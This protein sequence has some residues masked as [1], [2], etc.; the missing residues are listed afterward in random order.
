MDQDEDEG[1]SSA[2]VNGRKE[3]GGGVAG[4]APGKHK[5]YFKLTYYKF[6]N[7]DIGVIVE[8]GLSPPRERGITI[9]RRTMVMHSGV[10]IVLVHICETPVNTSYLAQSTHIRLM[11]SKGE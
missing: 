9:Y 2:V 3:D 8:W 4:A 5:G 1:D 7:R 11:E 10:S 6:C